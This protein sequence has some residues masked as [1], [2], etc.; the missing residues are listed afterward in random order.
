MAKID[1]HMLSFSAATEYLVRCTPLPWW[2]MLAIF[3]Y[4][5]VSCLVVNDAVKVVMIRW[6]VPT[7]AAQK[8]GVYHID[9]CPLR[10]FAVAAME[11]SHCLF[12]VASG[13]SEIE[14]TSL[15]MRSLIVSRAED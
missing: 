4:A 10:P 7:A 8:A 15:R 11:K 13:H 9:R 5:M 6:R 2:Q 1:T 3:A 14:T 12:W